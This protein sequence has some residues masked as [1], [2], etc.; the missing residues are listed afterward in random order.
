MHMVKKLEHKNTQG[1]EGL[2][3]P[4]F[5]QPSL[6]MPLL[7]ITCVFFKYAMHIPTYVCEFLFKFYFFIFNLDNPFWP[8]LASWALELR[9]AV[10]HQGAYSEP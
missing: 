7:T 5:S 3:H 2:P 8:Y 6:E 1:K 10:P 4:L 9:T